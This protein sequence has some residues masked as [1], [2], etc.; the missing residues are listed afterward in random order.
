VGWETTFSPRADQLALTMAHEVGHYLGLF[1][2][3]ERLPACTTSGQMDCSPWGGVD[4]IADTPT[5]ETNAARYIMYWLAVGG[6]E[7]LSPTQGL[8]WRRNPLVY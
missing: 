7:L 8:V 3:R 2:V 4:P 5:D 6:N 1:H